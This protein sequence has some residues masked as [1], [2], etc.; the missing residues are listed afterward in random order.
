VQE[1]P[2]HIEELIAKHLAFETTPAEMLELEGWLNADAEHR[3]YYDQLEILFLEG[4]DEVEVKVEDEA[5]RNVK[6]AIT[7]PKPV[8]K[9]NRWYYAAA[10]MLAVGVMLWFSL[11]QP[12]A[13]IAKT[14]PILLKTG[15]ATRTD[16][17]PDGTIVTL[18]KNSEIRTLADYGKTN[19]TLEMSGEVYFEVG[20]S[21]AGPF[22]IKTSKGEITDIGTAFSVNTVTDS[23]LSINVTHGEVQLKTKSA[24]VV[25]AKA[26]QQLVYNSITDKN[27]IATVDPNAAAFKTHTFEFK[28]AKLK[29]ILEQLNAVYGSNISCDKAL[30][31]CPITVNFKNEKI[32]TIVDIISET[33]NIRYE[34]GKGGF[35]LAGNQCN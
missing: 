16:T 13:E 31:N 2:S 9:I 10:A 28:G 30:E 35:H 8:L 15:S 22:I 4:E 19:R 33:L 11:S 7:R 3:A 23:I 27:E 32:E 6:E 12:K 1:I 34:K 26:G 14:E 20:K 18:N 24:H 21:N 5:W 29:T 17:L 25:N